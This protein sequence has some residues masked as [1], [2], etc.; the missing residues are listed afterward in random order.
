M[1]VAFAFSEASSKWSAGHRILERV[2]AERVLGYSDH[3]R[4][5]SRVAHHPEASGRRSLRRLERKSGRRRGVAARL[6][7]TVLNGAGPDR[8]E[9]H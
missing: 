1:R 4:G 3:W 9:L 8:S 2:L 7:S 5:A 6:L